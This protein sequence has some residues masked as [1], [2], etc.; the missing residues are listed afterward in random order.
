MHA[1]DKV[2]R[3]SVWCIAL[4]LMSMLAQAAPPTPLE[5]P[6]PERIEPAAISVALEPYLRAPQTTDGH[7]RGTRM[8]GI[9]IALPASAAYARVQALSGIPGDQRLALLDLRGIVYFSDPAGGAWRP[10]LDLREARANF[11]ADVFPNEAGLLGMAFHPQFNTPNTPG[12]GRFY[13]AFS[14]L[15]GSAEAHY[16]AADA[17]SHISVL[18]EWTAKDPRAERFAGSHRDL[19]RVGQ[20]APNHNIATLAFN[21]AAEVGGPDYGMLYVSMGD[22]GSAFDPQNYGQDLSAPLGAILRIDPLANAST[23]AY[24][25]PPDNPFAQ[26]GAGVA[27]EIWAYGLRHAQHFSFDRRGRMF[28][29]DIGQN[30]IEE[31]NLGVAGGNYGWRIREGTFATGQG[32]EEGYLGFMFKAPVD[33]SPLQYPIAQYDHDEGKAIGGGYFYEGQAIEAL[34]GK[35]VFSDLVAGRLFC[36]DARD[37]RSGELQKI[38]ELQV[39]VDGK[40]SDLLDLLGYENTYAPGQKR[41]DLRLG[42]DNSGELYV[43]SK[44]DGWVR[45][46]VAHVK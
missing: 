1:M 10:Y 39:Y 38:T 5:D 12:Y 34:T 6:I 29:N 2:K 18:S 40:P 19:L 21:P 37:V 41:A 4:L 17:A 16:Q 45:K 24:G 33:P 46:I 32:I 13:L 44:G 3:I 15:P 7:S 8:D 25:I 36:I 23:R 26:A 43:L 9:P 11:G 42:Q 20:F 22:G 14:A 31:V 35:Y 27:P 30:H 28:I